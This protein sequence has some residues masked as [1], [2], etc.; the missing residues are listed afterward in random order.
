MTLDLSRLKSIVYDS[1]IVQH[2]EISCADC[3]EQLDSFVDMVLAGKDAAQALPLVQDHLARCT[4]CRQEFEAL[5][6]TLRSMQDDTS[7]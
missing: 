2:L 5:L 3:F 6:Q 4:N 1:M 7:T